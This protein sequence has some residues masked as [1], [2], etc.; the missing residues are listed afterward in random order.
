MTGGVLLA[1]YGSVD[2]EDLHG[3]ALDVGSG[4]IVPA[5]ATD[6]SSGGEAA[7]AAPPDLRAVGNGFV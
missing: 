3:R 5:A 2:E 4:L 6:A 1:E 7:P